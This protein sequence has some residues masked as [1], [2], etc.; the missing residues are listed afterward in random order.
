MDDFEV[1][2][3]RLEELNRLAEQGRETVDHAANQQ[4]A[5]T[6]T[7]LKANK[8]I[9]KQQNRD[10]EKLKQNYKLLLSRLRQLQDEKE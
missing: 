3:K 8:K 10:L 1:M 4:L 5:I 9:L 7:L 6:K 2:Y